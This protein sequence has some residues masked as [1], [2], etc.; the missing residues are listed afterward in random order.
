VLT[1]ADVC[2]SFSTQ[3]EYNVRSF[4]EKNRDTI[5]ESLKTVLNGSEQMLM[6]KLL[7][8]RQYLKASCTSNLR[9]R[10]LVA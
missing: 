9:P 3:V 10:T 5:N 2:T 7:I 4:L 6:R 1:Y 8:S